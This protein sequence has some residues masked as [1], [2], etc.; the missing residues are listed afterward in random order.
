MISAKAP[1]RS[2]D[3][4]GRITTVPSE[5]HGGCIIIIEVNEVSVG[6]PV[7]SSSLG[8]PLGAVSG[9][10]SFLSAVEAGASGPGGSILGV[11]SVRVSYFHESSVSGVRLIRSSLVSVCS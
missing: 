10:V 9:K 8:V 4:I 11:L 7:P 5:G 3:R 2:D 1:A 6:A